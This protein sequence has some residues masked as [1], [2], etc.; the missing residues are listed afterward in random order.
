MAK[1]SLRSSAARRGATLIELMVGVV[2]AAV[3]TGA[4]FVFASHQTRHLGLSSMELDKDQV[5]RIALGMIARDLRHSGLG[6][7]Y[8][9]DGTFSGILLGNFTVRG[10]AAFDADDQDINL[11]Y[12]LNTSGLT[13]T[14]TT[15]TDDLGVRYAIGEYRTIANFG[16]GSGQACAGSGIVPG[17]AALLIANN[18]VNTQ[19]VII[20]SLTPATCSK[21][22]CLGGCESFTWTGDPTY[23]SSPAAASVSYLEGEIAGSFREVV[24]FVNVENG[25]G[26]L[27]RAE[28]SPNSQC[29]FRDANCGDVV[30]DSAEFL[31][32]AVWQWDSAANA[33]ENRTPFQTIPD[34]RRIRVDVELVLRARTSESGVKMPIQSALAGGECAPNPCGSRDGISRRAYRTS[35]EIRNAGRSLMTSRD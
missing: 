6:V 33:W 29:A 7:G 1:G 19:A 8:M 9:E 4:A 14:Y 12:G 28:I 18:G 3:V 27:R 15:E 2:I 22:I 30:T 16:P 34:R 13:G 21:G 31:H 24:W 11:E 20:N 17:D 26:T 35:V 5:G 23:R 10:G 25:R 32:F